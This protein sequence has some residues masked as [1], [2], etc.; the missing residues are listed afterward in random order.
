MSLLKT[1]RR[2][3]DV[4]SAHGA[5]GQSS[6]NEIVVQTFTHT[7]TNAG[8]TIGRLL[9]YSAGATHETTAYEMRRRVD[10]QDLSMWRLRSVG[11]AWGVG[12][13]VHWGGTVAG[14]LLPELTETYNIGSATFEVNNIYAQNAVTV[15]DRR[16][17]NDLGPIPGEQAIDFISKLEPRWF[18]YKD[19]E[20]SDGRVIK[21]SRPHTGF[22]AQQV[23]EAM[24]AAGIEDWAGYAYEKDEDT[25]VLRLLEMIGVLAAAVKHLAAGH[26]APVAAPEPEPEPVPEPSVDLAA[27]NEALRR[28]IAELETIPEPTPDPE[29][30]T[31]FA[32]L[33]LAD[34]TLDDAK[35]RLSQRL[36][37]LRHYLIAPEIKV[38]ED[39]SVGLTGDEQSELQDLER[40]Q[41]LGRWLDA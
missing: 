23:K 32:D 21:H 38:N 16:L 19:T 10:V 26:V 12:S 27:E 5:L 15:S 17:K 40:R 33:M 29:P 28:R 20:L 24:T 7:D 9:R 39:G 34:E 3:E 11:F 8:S 36:R 41:T 30:E 35:A 6:G 14:H 22:M 37:E 25:H 18:Q 4:S 2:M 31:H 13:T 1:N